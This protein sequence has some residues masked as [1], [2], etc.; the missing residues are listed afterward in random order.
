[1]PTKLAPR[2]FQP[3][4]LSQGKSHLW[5]EHRFSNGMQAR[6]CLHYVALRLALTEELLPA[7]AARRH[8]LK[9]GKYAEG[10]V[11]T[12]LQES[13]YH[14]AL[15]PAMSREWRSVVVEGY[16]Q[17][18][19]T[20]RAGCHRKVVGMKELGRLADSQVGAQG[21]RVADSYR[22]AAAMGERGETDA[23]HRWVAGPS[24]GVVV[25][26]R[27]AMFYQKPPQQPQATS[28]PRLQQAKL[29]CLLWRGS[30]SLPRRH[31][32]SSCE[33]TV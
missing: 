15:V 27:M 19:E 3:V 12:W 23:G 8:A 10:A 30:C 24:Q 16:C 22:R 28:T 21:H 2:I 31:C 13:R 29:R 7:S 33:E 9:P 25:A 4:L 17:K 14:R 6:N 32:R 20:K 1:M 26:H 5:Q 11:L 18:A